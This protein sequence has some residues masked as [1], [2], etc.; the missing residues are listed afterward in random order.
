MPA[1]YS[2]TPTAKKLTLKN[3]MRVWFSDMPDSIRAEITDYGLELDELPAAE[4]GLNAAHIFVTTHDQLSSHLKSLRTKI[5]KDGQVWVSWPKKA[6]GV[7][8]EID[9]AAVQKAG[10][11]AGFVDTKKCAV[12]ET[13]SGLKF[14][15]PKAD[16]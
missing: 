13:W 16:R 14:V 9:Q 12:D 11:A 3:G 7:A 15:I 2:G 8:T 6:S 1:G 5:A 4:Q 10:L